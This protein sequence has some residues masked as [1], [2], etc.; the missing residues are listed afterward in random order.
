MRSCEF[1][2]SMFTFQVNFVRQ[3]ILLC[4][5][6]FFLSTAVFLRDP[7]DGQPLGKRILCYIAEVCVLIGCLISIFA[8]L[9]KEVYLQGLN[10]YLQTLVRTRKRQAH[11]SFAHVELDSRTFNILEKLSREITLSMFVHIDFVGRAVS[12]AL[13]GHGR[14]SVRLCRRWSRVIGSARNVSLLSL[15]RTDLR[16]NRRIHRH[17]IRNDF[18][19]H[20]NVRRD[21]CY[22]HHCVRS[23]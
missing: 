9:A 16:V 4:L 22:C 19:R 11:E 10:Y 18:G 8:L 3:L 12:C 20:C 15:L 17:D 21:L 23:R 5:H 2:F 7:K 6:L 14:Y 13:F 1:L